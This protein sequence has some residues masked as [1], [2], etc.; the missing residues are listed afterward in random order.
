MAQV[1]RR[2]ETLDTHEHFQIET[3]DTYEHFRIETLDTAR[4]PMLAT[5]TREYERTVSAYSAYSAYKPELESQNRCS[6]EAHRCRPIASGPPTMQ[7]GILPLN[8][9]WVIINP[10]P[11]R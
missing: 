9:P 4:N 7:K 10:P 2:T 1:T 3:L 11:L 5:A 8:N 6:L